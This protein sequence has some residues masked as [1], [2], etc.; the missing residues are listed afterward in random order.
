MQ[1]QGFFCVQFDFLRYRY[2]GIIARSWTDSILSLISG[3][4]IVSLVVVP[5]DAERNAETPKLRHKNCSY[6]NIGCT[7]HNL[8]L[9]SSYI[10]DALLNRIPH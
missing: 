7:Q 2:I 10:Y 1:E 8:Q 4:G 5:F 9:K 6:Y 3:H